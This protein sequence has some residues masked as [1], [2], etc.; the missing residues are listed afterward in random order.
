M[1]ISN[2]STTRMAIPTGKSM[3]FG[4]DISIDGTGIM[5]PSVAN[6]FR[7]PMSVRRVFPGKCFIRKCIALASSSSI[8]PR[9][10]IP[11]MNF[12]NS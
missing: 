2:R 11:C 7:A 1:G 4:M 9:L 5:S 6:G 10:A 12:G 3:D 8:G